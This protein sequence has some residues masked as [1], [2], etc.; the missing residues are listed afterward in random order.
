MR[1]LDI[2]FTGRGQHS[3]TFSDGHCDSMTDP[4]QSE[5]EFFIVRIGHVGYTV[6]VTLRLTFCMEAVGQGNLNLVY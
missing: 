5:K 3:N 1:G 2:N 6:K 4:A